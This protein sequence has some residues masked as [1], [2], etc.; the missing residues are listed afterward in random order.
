M[1]RYGEQKERNQDLFLLTNL[2][3]ELW[4]PKCMDRLLANPGP[5]E[6]LR[7]GEEPQFNT[8][9][10][11]IPRVE[12]RRQVQVGARGRGDGG[13]R[14]VGGRRARDQRRA[15]RLAALA[16]EEDENEEDADGVRGRGEE[17]QMV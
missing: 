6:W 3:Y 12:Q 15:R 4:A 14:G 17:V 5:W 10:L 16:E 9:P 8:P 1:E 13:G 11:E 2:N 7:N